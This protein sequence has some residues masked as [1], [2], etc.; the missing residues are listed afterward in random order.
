MAVFYNQATLTY[1]GGTVNSNV[2]SGEI[3]EALH[4]TK[5][6]IASG[7]VPGGTVTYA[8]SIV[9]D[10]AVDMTGLTVT[11]DLGAYAAGPDTLCP[12][13]YEA[14]SAVLYVDGAVQ[15][16]PA[17]TAGPPLT[18][19]G[20]DVPAGSNAMLLYRARVTPFAPLGTDARI[21]NTASV[22]GGCAAA[23]ASAALPMTCSAALSIVKSVSPEVVAGCGEL[24]YTFS[25]R[26]TGADPA[27][28]ADAVR[29]SDTFDPLL[30]GL[31]VTL[32]GVPLVPGTDYAYDESTGVF[33]TVPGRITVPAA[34]F[35]PQPD[36]AWTVT[37]GICELQVTGSLM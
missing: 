15:A 5:T 14:D 23:T 8:L 30:R 35:A 9:N 4:V 26:N 20:V 6:P 2:A 17:V 21:V 16:A 33:T 25:I 10:G 12:L 28:A 11:D 24:T 36:G 3:I 22:T 27:G 29:L 18:V 13:A 7:Y 37:P 1:S 32:D 31:S 34:A 19:T